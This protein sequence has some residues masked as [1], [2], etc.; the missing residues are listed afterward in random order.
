MTTRTIGFWAALSMT[1]IACGA[2]EV[3]TEGGGDDGEIA[4]AAQAIEGFTFDARELATA[5]AARLPAARLTLRSFDDALIQ[6]SLIGADQ[7]FTPLG[8]L[9]RRTEHESADWTYEK[10]PSNGQVLVLRKTPSGPRISP[11]EALLRRNALA[12]LNSWGIPNDEIG[13]VVQRRT[14]R[15]DQDGTAASAPEVHRYKTFVFRAVNGVRV[16][17]HRAVVTHTLD[18]TFN[19]ALIRW[20]AIASTGHRLRTALTAPEIERRAVEALSA[21]GERGGSVRLRWKYVA[22]PLTSGEVTLTL[23]VGAILGAGATPS[24]VTEEPREV[25]IDVAAL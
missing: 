15:E 6:R 5:P 22:T 12:R 24:G 13:A 18:G 1:L 9:G 8:E 14:L 7:Q 17:G 21:E 4:A 3:A 16:Q 11:D 25:D 20:P 10:D 23:T 19:R 2:P